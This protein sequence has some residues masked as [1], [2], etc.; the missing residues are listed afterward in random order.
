MLARSQPRSVG[1]GETPSRPL[2]TRSH[3]SS[4]ELAPPGYLQ[5]IPTMA[6]GSSVLTL[7]DSLSSLVFCWRRRSVSS[8][9]LRRASTNCSTDVSMSPDLRLLLL[10]RC[11]GGSHQVVDIHVL[12]RFGVVGRRLRRGLR[13]VSEL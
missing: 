5:A 4:G 7:P 12:D 1:N 8:I 2:I 9:D 13:H 11:E 10:D 6:M 3:S